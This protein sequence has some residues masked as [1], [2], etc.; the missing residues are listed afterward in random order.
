LRKLLLIAAA[1]IIFAGKSNAEDRMTLS[2]DQ[3][4]KIGLEK[5]KSVSIS[6][7]KF[8]SSASK[9]EESKASGLPSVKAQG[10]YTRL[11]E[12][13]PMKFNIAGREMVLAPSILNNYQL[14]LSVAQPIFTGNRISSSIEMNE[15]L[16]S[17]SNEDLSQ[18]KLTLINDIKNSYWS[19]YKAL[20]TKETIEKNIE[21][22]K[23]HLIDIQNSYQAGLAIENDVLKVKVQLSNL[24][25]NKIEAQNNIE[26]SSIGLCNVLGIDVSSEIELSDKPEIN[27]ITRIDLREATNLAYK[28]RNDLKAQEFRTKAAESA[29]DVAKSG[30]FPQINVAANYTYANP[31]SRIQP[32]K[33][34]FKGTW[35]IGLSL[36]YDIWNW[37]TTAKQEE[38]AQETLI[39]AKLAKEQIIDAISVETKQNAI[40]V[41]RHIDKVK[42]SQE[43]VAQ[44]KENLRV[45]NEKFKAGAAINSDLLDAETSLLQAEINYISII[46]D[47]QIALA[48]YE[49]SIAKNY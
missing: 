45:T 14:K 46:C 2:L 8:R 19:Y 33:E 6:A 32:A 43:V 17:A 21:Q 28:Q 37:N 16:N 30:Y 4:V 20:R 35:D 34:E 7:S 13:D 36:S 44:A 47:Y 15:F 22:V 25:L 9:I 40:V 42:A 29:I 49:K 31:N 26:V 18:T 39:Q 11:S 23:S 10:A 12:V 1:A 48:K 41:N 38:Q 3:A 5:N 27:N 24:E